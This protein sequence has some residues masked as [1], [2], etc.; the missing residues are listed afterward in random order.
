MPHIWN[1]YD[2]LEAQKWVFHSNGQIELRC[3][4]LCLDV[5]DGYNGNDRVAI[6]QLYNCIP[7]NKNQEWDLVSNSPPS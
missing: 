5:K 7:G 3:T 1:C 4:G 6:V 2:G